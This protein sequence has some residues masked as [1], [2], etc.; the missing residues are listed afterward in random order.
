MNLDENYKI[1]LKSLKEK[2]RSAQIKASIAVNEE[3]L[4]LYW[5]IGK[6]I[7]E[8]QIQFTWGSKIVEQMAKDL[9]RELPDTNGFSRTNL[10]AM[11]KF[12]LFYKDSYLVHQVGGQ[13]ENTSSNTDNELVQQLGGQLSNESILCKI[14][15]RH[16]IAILSNC[17]TIKESLFYIQQTIQNNWSRNILEI[18]IESKLIERQGK[19]INNFEVTLP[20][21]LS[22]LAK[23]TLKDPY[24]F[25]FV[26][27]ES[28]VQE[29]QLEKSLTDNITHFLLELG[30]GFAFVGRQYSLLVGKKERKIDL[31]FYHLKMH[32]YVVIDLKMGEFEPEYAGKMNY[33][34][35]AVDKLIKTEEDNPSIGIILCKS[36][37]NLEVEFALQDFNKPM[38]ISEFTFNELP[39]NI[40]INMPTIQELENEL[41]NAK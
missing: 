15:W 31:L 3:M 14:P 26:T 29:L 25:G 6:S 28:E 24:K 21:S 7:V 4:L 12:Y 5:D 30:K 11:R 35:S 1:W 37:D 19:A 33:Y 8:K 23:E 34:L 9:K 39:E 20:K 17:S 10:F 36:K 32:C 41:N 2:I 40:K 16:H 27:L 18:Q 38:G 13:I 22:D